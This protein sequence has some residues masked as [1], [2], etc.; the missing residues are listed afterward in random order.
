MLS[1]QARAI[2]PSLQ[3][4]RREADDRLGRAQAMP[5]GQRS[6]GYGHGSSPY[7]RSSGVYTASGKAV[8]NV[9]AYAATGAPT[10]SRAGKTISNPVAYS[11]AIE[12]SV[13]QNTSQP[14]YL[15]HYT[16]SSSLD[17]IESSGKLK[18]STGPGDCALGQGV[19]FTAKPPRSSTNSLLNNNYDGAAGAYGSSHVE[20]Y[21]RVD[22]DKVNYKSGRSDLN[23]DVFVVP[24]NVNL[25]KAGGTTGHRL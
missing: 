23:R 5:K 13:H 8:R 25:N 24:G 1:R 4:K 11:G 19:Y 16:S 3:E 18:K 9:A 6:G 20:S 10:Y 14:K 21:V 12:A 22:A 7:S 17:Q 15:Y 2:H